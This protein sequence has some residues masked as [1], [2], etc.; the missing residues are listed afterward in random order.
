MDNSNN[1][2]IDNSIP[3]FVAGLQKNSVAYELSGLSLL[4]KRRQS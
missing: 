2:L 3:S 1:S 4:A